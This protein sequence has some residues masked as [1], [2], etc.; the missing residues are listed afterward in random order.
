MA[1][2][3]QALI[4]WAPVAQRRLFTP[5]EDRA[6][7]WAYGRGWPLKR[8]AAQCDRQWTVIQVRVQWLLRTGALQ[9]RRRL[10]G[11]RWT[12][13]EERKLAAWWGL[14]PDTEL[15]A[16]F[17]RSPEALKI[18]ATRFLRQARKD[19]LLNARQVGRLFGVDQ[20]TVRGWQ[21]RG[22]VAAER[23]P[24]GAGGHARMWSFASST[25]AR[26]VRTRPW[27]VDPARMAPNHWLTAVAQQAQAADPWLMLDEAAARL[28]Y[29]PP[30]VRRW[31]HRLGWAHERAP[32]LGTQHGPWQ[33]RIVLREADLP[34][35][36]DAIVATT[37]ANR[38]RAM[39][40]IARRR[41]WQV[42]TPDAQ[43]A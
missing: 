28:G 38:A 16:E 33:G 1:A 10:N 20:K 23:S 17:G 32:K 39:R 18:R 37:H 21:R 2:F 35:L 30:I 9:E 15:A 6:I 29:V 27:C 34:A 25:L 36:G 19:N 14:K 4:E 5:S 22:W 41:G 8:I 24:V 13:A 12:P 40:E 3:D 7:A 11:P 43:E 42:Q 31:V 26:F